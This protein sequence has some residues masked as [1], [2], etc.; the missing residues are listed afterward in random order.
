MRTRRQAVLALCG[1]ALSTIGCVSLKRT[2]GARFFVLRSMVEPASTAASAVEALVGVAPVALPGSLDRAQVVA[3]KAPGELRIDEFL[4]WA[5][6]LDAGITRVLSENL[7]VL[8]PRVRVV[9]YPWPA[10]AELRCRVRVELG[11]FGPQP[12]GEVRLEGRWA[13][14][15]QRD[16]RPYVLRSVSLRRGPLEAA[17]TGPD[18]SLV[19]EAMSG[20]VADLSREIAGA[21]LDLPPSPD[22]G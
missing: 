2:P 15:P 4:R 9:R 6:P 13:L 1:L 8:L 20:L 11:L 21:I 19:V 10:S 18:A 5:E 12:D 22:A 17:P 14:L 16:E 7:A 3:W